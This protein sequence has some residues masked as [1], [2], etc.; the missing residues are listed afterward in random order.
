[1]HRLPALRLL[2][3]LHRPFRLIST[4]ELLHSPPAGRVFVVRTDT[5]R[6]ASGATRTWAALGEAPVVAFDV[7]FDVLTAP[8]WPPGLRAVVVAHDATYV[9]S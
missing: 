7:S 1:M 5:W 8:G 4:P 6:A 3:P 2:T 9:V